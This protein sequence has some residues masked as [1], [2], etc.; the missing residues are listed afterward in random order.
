V[1]RAWRFASVAVTATLLVVRVTAMAL[2]NAGSVIV[3]RNAMER[4]RRAPAA[5][6]AVPG[7]QVDSAASSLLGPAAT[8]GVPSSRVAGFSDLLQG[9][10]S[11]AVA[12]FDASGDDT[13]LFWSGN[14]LMRRGDRDGA[15]Q[16]WMRATPTPV[17]RVELAKVVFDQ[18]NDGV[19][20]DDRID[21]AAQI[22]MSAV[23]ISR[24]RHRAEALWLAVNSFQAER[25]TAIAAQLLAGAD[26][27]RDPRLMT[28][29]AF[30]ALEADDD[31]AALSSANRSLAM[32]D[33]WLARYVRGMVEVRQCRTDA[34]LRDFEAGLALPNDGDYRQSWLH[35]RLGSVRWV[36][37]DRDG[38]IREWETY[39][40]LQP[41]DDAVGKLLQ[42]ARSG[43]LV[44]D[45]R[46]IR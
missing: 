35:E 38:A 11:D 14:V 22:A 46:S 45:C 6:Y 37:G 32:R 36:R 8:L 5:R 12:A 20:H 30:G 44:L 34:A 26:A 33:V 28:L 23:G 24:G 42:Q 21:D 4:W 40:A 31:A 41:G 7:T 16:R 25:K 9:R 2:L 39:A 3:E 13:A 15:R 19:Q 17:L 27:E 10:D 1:T 43:T 29:R 18:A